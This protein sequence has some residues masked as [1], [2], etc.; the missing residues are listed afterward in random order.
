MWLPDKISNAVGHKKK[1]SGVCFHFTHYN[2][3]FVVFFIQMDLLWRISE[4]SSVTLTH[5]KPRNRECFQ[6]VSLVYNQSYSSHCGSNYNTSNRPGKWR[7]YSP[8]WTFYVSLFSL[9]ECWLHVTKF[10]KDREKWTIA[11][12]S[13]TTGRLT[14]WEI[15][16]PVHL[17]FQI[18]F[19]ECPL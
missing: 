7:K 6:A 8:C 11:S 2:S 13:C 19:R 17:T 12:A 15:N 14:C 4:E 3:E 16:V 10:S 1:Y 9:Y 18:I 5:L